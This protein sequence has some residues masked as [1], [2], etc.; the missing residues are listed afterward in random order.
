M[1]G[2]VFSLSLSPKV[3]IYLPV[4]SFNISS[5]GPCKGK[6]YTFFHFDLTQPLDLSSFFNRLTGLLLF[7]NFL[8]KLN[9]NAVTTGGIFFLFETAKSIPFN[10]SDHQIYI[11]FVLAD[12]CRCLRFASMFNWCVNCFFLPFYMSCHL[13]K[14]KIWNRIYYHFCYVK[15]FLLKTTFV[16]WLPDVSGWRHNSEGRF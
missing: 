13:V 8:I 15:I 6:S 14:Q 12:Y 9:S 5:S 10:L 2:R 11:G 16:L 7:F 1:L 3:R 4:F